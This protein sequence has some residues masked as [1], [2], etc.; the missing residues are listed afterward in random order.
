MT[1]LEIALCVLFG[2]VIALFGLWVVGSI[3][4]IVYISWILLFALFGSEWAL[5]KWRSF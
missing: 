4:G 3:F 2:P 1:I 5:E